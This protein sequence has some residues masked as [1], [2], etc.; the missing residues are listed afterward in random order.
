MPRMQLRGEQTK[1]R[2]YGKIDIVFDSYKL[3]R[4]ILIQAAECLLVSRIDF[5]NL[6]VLVNDLRLVIAHLVDLVR[7]LVEV[8][9]PND[10]TKQLFAA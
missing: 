10:H 1:R 7:D 9:L 6:R 4:R 5:F 2:D 3:R 8:R